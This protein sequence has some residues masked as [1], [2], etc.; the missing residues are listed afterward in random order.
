MVRKKCLTYFPWRKCGLSN[1]SVIREEGNKFLS[2]QWY[3]GARN[4][5]F[6]PSVLPSLHI[7]LLLIHQRVLACKSLVEVIRKNRRRGRYEIVVS[8]VICNHNDSFVDLKRKYMLQSKRSALP[9]CAWPGTR[10]S[11][12]DLRQRRGLDVSR[13]SWSQGAFIKFYLKNSFE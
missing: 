10:R 1:Y 7:K 2:S 6:N 4:L 13:W 9:Q 3:W 8:L 11:G 12:F 5:K